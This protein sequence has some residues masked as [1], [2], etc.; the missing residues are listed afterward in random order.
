MNKLH[1]LEKDINWDEL[2]KRIVEKLPASLAGYS[3]GDLTALNFIR[4]L[5]IQRL[6]KLNEMELEDKMIDRPSYRRFAGIGNADCPHYSKP[7]WE[8]RRRLESEGKF[9]E[10]LSSF[11]HLLRNPHRSSGQ[12]KMA[13]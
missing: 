10:V 6:Y 12:L 1:D 9:N 4:L 5:Y 3:A 2:G 7:L 11:E 8:F 13:S